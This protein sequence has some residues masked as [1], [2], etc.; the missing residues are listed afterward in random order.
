M[1]SKLDYMLV[2]VNKNFLTLLP[3]PISFFPN[4]KIHDGDTIMILLQSTDLTIDEIR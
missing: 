3:I 1:K 2:R 4:C